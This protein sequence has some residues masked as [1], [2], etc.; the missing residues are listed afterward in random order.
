MPAA[1][2]PATVQL[3][4]TVLSS[5]EASRVGVDADSNSDSEEEKIAELP[6]G[7]ALASVLSLQDGER[8]EGAS[9]ADHHAVAITMASEEAEPESATMTVTPGPYEP[10]EKESSDSESRAPPLAPDVVVPAPVAAVVAEVASEL[11]HD[12]E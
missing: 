4:V 6:E 8:A 10:E 5:P 3:L 1:P 11:E 12:S 7:P 9:P 2:L